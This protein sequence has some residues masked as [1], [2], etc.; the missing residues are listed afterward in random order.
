M[1]TKKATLETEW[2]IQALIGRCTFNPRDKYPGHQVTQNI[3]MVP[4]D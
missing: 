3:E 1:T 2:I 4:N